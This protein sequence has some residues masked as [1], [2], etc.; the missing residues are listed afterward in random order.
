MAAHTIYLEK[1][2][3]HASK[4]LIAELGERGLEIAAEQAPGLDAGQGEVLAGGQRL[5]VE[6]LAPVAVDRLSEESRGM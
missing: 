4:L 6:R 5:I 1:I 2:S 3:P